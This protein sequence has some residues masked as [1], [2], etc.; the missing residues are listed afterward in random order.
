MGENNTYTPILIDNKLANSM[1]TK[2]Y[3]MGGANQD[4]YKMVHMENGVSLWQINFDK[5]GGG[6]SGTSN[7]TNSTN[8]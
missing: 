2:L 6:T 7:S 1:F 4:I 8:K 5:V 3:L